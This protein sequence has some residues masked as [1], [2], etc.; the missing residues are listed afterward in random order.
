[1]GNYRKLS[2]C[3]YYIKYHI[4]WITEYHKPVIAGQVAERTRETIGQV[5]K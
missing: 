5:C 4:V 3:M 1:M 2:H